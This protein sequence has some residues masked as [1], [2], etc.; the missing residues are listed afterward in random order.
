MRGGSRS[1][2]CLEVDLPRQPQS[3]SHTPRRVQWQVPL[4][5]MISELIL[6]EEN[7]DV[8]DWRVGGTD[9]AQAKGRH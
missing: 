4:L 5:G 8:W 7:D 3:V 9:A 2:P 1:D 6:N